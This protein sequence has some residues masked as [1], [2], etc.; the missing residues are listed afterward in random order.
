[1]IVRAI[2]AI[3]ALLA[4]AR[5]PAPAQGRVA[6][7]EYEL[8]GPAAGV[9]LDAGSAGTTR[10]E[11]ALSAGET[12]RFVA[13]IPTSPGAPPL[14]PR[15]RSTTGGARF[16]GWREPDARLPA[17]PSALRARP[18]PAASSARVRVPPSVLLVLAAAGIAGLWLRRSP[19][20][21]L[22]LGIAAAAIAFALARRSL[23][24]D[25]TAVEILDGIAGAPTWQRARAARD[26]LTLPSRSPGYELRTEPAGAPL[27]ISLA[28]DPSSL[29]RAASAGARLIAIWPETWPAD[30]LERGANHLVELDATWFR[31]EGTWTSRGPWPIGSPLGAAR[32]GPDPPGW[33]IDG[34]PQGVQVLVGRV[35]G[36]EW[37]FVRCTF[38]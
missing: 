29:P 34:L 32:P 2:A 21:A 12:S 13:P 8:H 18:P 5:A 1:V 24:R 9:V 23:A 11:G 28:L 27:A 31:D 6:F 33:L 36:E 30:A 3:L 19:R 4:L 38:P 16:L 37:S 25:A 14:E 26:A 17:L 35:A 15:V 7:G 10:L 22:A 20:A